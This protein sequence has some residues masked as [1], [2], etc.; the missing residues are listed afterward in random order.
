LGPPELKGTAWYRLNHVF[1]P[2]LV[3][4]FRFGF[5]RN[6]S[7]A[8][9]D[10]FGKNQVDEFVP[11]VPENPA[12][13]AE[14]PRSVLRTSA[15]SLPARPIF[16]RAAGAAAISI[17]RHSFEDR[18]KALAEIRRGFARADAQPLSR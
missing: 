3:N 6:Y 5:I 9:Q 10:P 17:W 16:F 12:V 14:F 15:A 18:R 11:G 1:S 4:E 2:S 13:A 8:E 7:F